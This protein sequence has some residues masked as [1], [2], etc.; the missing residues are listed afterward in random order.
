[1]SF[2]AQ[3]LLNTTLI[4]DSADNTTN[5]LKTIVAPME[6]QYLTDTN[7]WFLLTK[8]RGLMATDREDVSLDFWYDETNKNYYA[9]I[10]TRF[11]GCATNWRYMF[12][13][14]MSTS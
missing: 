2:T 1:M 8:G 14:S 4:P 3:E 10:F 5:V 13:N 7:A 12:G 6:W 9:S 11:G